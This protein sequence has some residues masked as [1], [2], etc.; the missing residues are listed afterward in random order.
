MSSHDR[1]QYLLSTAAVGMSILALLFAFLEMRST[2]RQLDANVW[3]YVA[4]E[5]TLELDTVHL[6]LVNKGLGPAS[7]QEFHL[8]QDAR[9]VTNPLEL[10]DDL[11]RDGGVGFSGS[12]MPGTVL[13]VGERVTAFRFTG[14]GI[15]LPLMESMQS[16]TVEICY[17]S[18]HNRCWRDRDDNIRAATPVEECRPNEQSLLDDLIDALNEENAEPGS[19]ENTDS[20]EI[21]ETDGTE[22]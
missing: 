8:S 20:D 11:D 21:R 4:I 1:N 19:A 16:L 10:L 6:E 5:L 3:P 17:C 15:G 12:E 9:A 14:E 2:E 18:I 13:A 22:P 7:L